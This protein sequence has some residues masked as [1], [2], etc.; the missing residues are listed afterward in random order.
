MGVSPWASRVPRGSYLPWPEAVP[1]FEA[2]KMKVTGVL[3][4]AKGDQPP[5]T[6]RPPPRPT[7]HSSHAELELPKHAQLFQARGLCTCCALCLEYCLLFRL[8]HVY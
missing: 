2:V 5:P 3:N 4:S 6:P 7:P 1:A 8:V